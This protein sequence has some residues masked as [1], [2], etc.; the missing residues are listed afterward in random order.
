LRIYA[1]GLRGWLAL[2]DTTPDR[3]RRV[4]AR[5]RSM[6]DDLEGEPHPL[7]R[8]FALGLK[9]SLAVRRGQRDAAL[10]VLGEL[11]E[12]AEGLG[13]EIDAVTA[14]RCMGQLLGGAGRPLVA[15]ADAWMHAQGVVEPERLAQV[16]LYVPAACPR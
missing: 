15:E 16:F 12:H 1:R 9:A 4:L 13:H 5:A 14:R 2:A 3:E 7:A 6:I 8:L 10:T 11:M